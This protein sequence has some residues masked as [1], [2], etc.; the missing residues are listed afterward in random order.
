MA[1]NVGVALLVMTLILCC[2][3]PALKAIGL[4]TTVKQMSAV[5]WSNPGQKGE[6]VPLVEVTT[7][8]AKNVGPLPEEVD[9]ILWG[10]IRR[11]W[12][13]IMRLLIEHGQKTNA[14]L[15]IVRVA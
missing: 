3:F 8:E 2:A 9:E 7:P 12:E 1:I 5:V 15:G 10:R 11:G 13:E 4:Y 6:E 14:H